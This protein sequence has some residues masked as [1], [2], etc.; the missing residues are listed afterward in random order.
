MTGW[1]HTSCQVH[2]FEWLLRLVFQHEVV[3][4]DQEDPKKQKQKKTGIMRIFENAEN[5]NS[6][7]VLEDYMDP[8]WLSI[9]LQQIGP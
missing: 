6:S 4:G 2:W 8:W 1:S 5:K 3:T 9:F 7:N